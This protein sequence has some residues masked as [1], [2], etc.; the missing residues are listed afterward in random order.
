M[1]N[2]EQSR[3]EVY[4]QYNAGGNVNFVHFSKD[5]R[6]TIQLAYRIVQK[7]IQSI[8]KKINQQEGFFL[9]QKHSYTT[10]ELLESPH[11][12]RIYAVTEKLGDDVTNWRRFGN[13]SDAEKTFYFCVR[14]L[15]ESDLNQVTTQIVSRDSTWVDKVLNKLFQ[16][17][18]Y[19]MTNLPSILPT[20]L[21]GQKPAKRLLPWQQ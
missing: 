12:N 18:A 6:D 8:Q 15:I 7:E 9:F 14:E 1:A 13:L 21:E 3:Q 19:V 16:F 5:R 4:A 11:H 2:Y 20:Y 17:I 10:S